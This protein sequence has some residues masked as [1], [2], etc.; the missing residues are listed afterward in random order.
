[1]NIELHKISESLPLKEEGKVFLLLMKEFPNAEIAYWCK[2]YAVFIGNNN[3]IIEPSVYD[4]WAE[5][6]LVAW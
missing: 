2:R 3:D 6:K 1:M 5:V 4:Y